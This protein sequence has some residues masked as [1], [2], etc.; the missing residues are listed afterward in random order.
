MKQDLNH[1]NQVI[2]AKQK[3]ELGATPCQKGTVI[4]KSSNP[5]KFKRHHKVDFQKDKGASHQLLH[6]T[7]T[8]K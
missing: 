8:C 4:Y 5:N 2:P 3:T 1:H 6:S 7:K